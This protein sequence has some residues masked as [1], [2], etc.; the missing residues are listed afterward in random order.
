MQS[1]L[2]QSGPSPY[3]LSLMAGTLLIAVTAYPKSLDESA[4]CTEKTKPSATQS[5]SLASKNATIP[6]K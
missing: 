5:V 3:F 6:H 4:I 2:Q 1:V